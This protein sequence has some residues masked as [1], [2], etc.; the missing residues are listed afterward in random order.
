LLVIVTIAS[1][2]TLPLTLLQDVDSVLGKAGLKKQV[3]SVL[4]PGKEF[5]TTYEGPNA[6]KEQISGILRPIT[7]PNGATFSID[8]EESV[9]FP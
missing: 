8:V 3:R 9:S 2:T 6:S 5:S 7:Q 4:V 1:K